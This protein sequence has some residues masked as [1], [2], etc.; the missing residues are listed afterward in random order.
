LG[1]D[2]DG[3]L[4]RLGLFGGLHPAMQE[5]ISS[6]IDAGNSVVITRGRR[7]VGNRESDYPFN[8]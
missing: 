8:F 4:E 7:Q 2:G 5:S 1:E 3:I 6:R